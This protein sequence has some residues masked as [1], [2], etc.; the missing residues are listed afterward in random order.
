MDI[1]SIIRDIP[2]FPKPGIIFK[3]ITPLLKNPQAFREAVELLAESVEGLGITDVVGIE[4]RGFIFGSALAMRLGVGFVFDPGVFD[5]V[6]L[7]HEFGYTLEYPWFGRAYVLGVEPMS[8]LP[9][10]RESG[11][12]LLRLD[13]ESS[14]ETDFLTVAYEATGVRRISPAGVVTPK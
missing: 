4:A 13:G 2:D 5:C 9:G 6:W 1:K 14:L 11:G 10:A 8:S 3:D 7:W 12:R